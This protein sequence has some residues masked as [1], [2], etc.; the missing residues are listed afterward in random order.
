MFEG[1]K[2]AVIV[3][4][5]NGESYRRACAV[6]EHAWDAGAEVRVR[7]ARLP[8]AQGSHPHWSALPC[9][10]DDVPELHP[11]DIGWADVVISH[12]GRASSAMSDHGGIGR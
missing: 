7:R 3:D 1:V 12:G 6:A 2:V 9:E 10:I 11:D 4:D 8:A 5:T